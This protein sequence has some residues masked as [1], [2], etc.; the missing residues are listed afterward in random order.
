MKNLQKHMVAITKKVSGA[1]GILQ[2]VE[3]N[4]ETNKLN[5]TDSH[6]LL[7][8]THNKEIKEDMVLNLETLE[9][10][11]G[12]YP[13]IERLF[14][15]T[16]S[17]A[18]INLNDVDGELI[19]KLTSH[20]KDIIELVMRQDLIQINVKPMKENG[21]EADYYTGVATLGFIRVSDSDFNNEE[22]Y[23]NAEY[24]RD[25]FKFMIDFKKENKD[26]NVSLKINGSVRPIMFSDNNNQFRYV[27]T[28]IRIS[29]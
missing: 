4:S 26:S 7:S 25:C 23:F 24:L 17:D 3:F 5:C 11:D 20:K 14:P 10:L 29:Q 19:K 15:T 12:N 1:R 8:V 9:Q 6:R 28:P 22:I 13:Q 16:G 21:Y 18:I 2:G 27:I